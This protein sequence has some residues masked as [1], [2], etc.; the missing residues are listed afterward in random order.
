MS[1]DKFFQYCFWGIAIASYILAVVCLLTGKGI[2]GTIIFI[3]LGALTNYLGR[4]V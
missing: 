1:V 4:K 3:A 2:Y